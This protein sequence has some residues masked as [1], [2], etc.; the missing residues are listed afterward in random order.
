[1]DSNQ[2]R[3][4]CPR[5]EQRNKCKPKTETNTKQE[6]TEEQHLTIRHAGRP[7]DLCIFKHLENIS[8]IIMILND[9]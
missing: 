8:F 6:Q 7:A 4:S 9:I 3:Q 5:R 2:T 1:M